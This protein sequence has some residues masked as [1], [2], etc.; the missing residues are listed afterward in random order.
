MAQKKYEEWVSDDNLTLLTA[1]AR[2]GMEKQ[3]IAKK[4]GM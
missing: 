2:D 4:I 1:W 3:E